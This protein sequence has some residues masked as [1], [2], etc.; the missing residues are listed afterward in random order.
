[1]LLLSLEDEESARIYFTELGRLHRD[2]ISV[3]FARHLGTDPENVV[4][5]ARRTAE[6]TPADEVW[7]VFDTEGPQHPA[8][9][10]QA[11]RA[12]ARARDLA[13]HCAVSNP[14]FEY[15]LL[16]H[17]VNSVRSYP[18]C[19]VVAREL[20]EHVPNYDKGRLRFDDFRERIGDAQ[21]RARNNDQTRC[22]A[23]D[24]GPVD[25]HP[26]TQVYLLVERFLG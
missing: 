6:A 22:Q 4:E 14:C 16:L 20:R 10:P 8:R 18:E 17:F 7:C 19:K 21:Q 12:L 2:R 26:C 9:A 5:A 3:V 15:W 23:L 11:R 24:R 25:C 13:Y 1:V